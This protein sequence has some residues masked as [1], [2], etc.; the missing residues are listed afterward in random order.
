[1]YRSFY[2]LVFYVGTDKKLFNLQTSINEIVCVYENKRTKYSKFP[3][4]WC[5]KK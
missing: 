2:S 5:Y 4:K 3:I 1:M